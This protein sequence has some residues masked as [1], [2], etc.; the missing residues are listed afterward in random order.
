MYH[1]TETAISMVAITVDDFLILRNTQTAVDKFYKTLTQKYSLK[2]SRLPIN[3]P[4]WTVSYGDDGAIS[5]PQPS[6]CMPKIS[7]ASFDG[8]HGRC[9]PYDYKAYFRPPE[10]SDAHLPATEA[11]YR[12]LVG[13]LR[14]LA[15]ITRPD[16][17]YVKG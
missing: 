16:L 15:D 7:N 3:F 5:L 14:Y 9:I 12:H 17:S 1:R 10:A 2:H 11:K 4:G 8:L 13:D 6:L